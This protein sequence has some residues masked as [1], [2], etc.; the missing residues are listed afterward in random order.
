[1]SGAADPLAGV[2]ADVVRLGR[3]VV[4]ARLVVAAGGN[5]AV[6]QPGADEVVVTP[7]ARPLDELDPDELPVVSLATGAVIATTATGGGIP[8]T[9]ELALHLAA[10]RARPDVTAVLHLHPPATTLLHAVGIPI[11]ALTTDHALALA[12]VA[13][14]PYLDPGSDELAAAVGAAVAGAD[15]VLLRHH[16]CVVVADSADVAFGRAANVEAAAE[17]TFRARQLGDHDTVC[18]PR[19]LEHLAAQEARGIRYGR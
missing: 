17:A 19:Y 1:M 8:P 10:L 13:E 4:A 6:R 2:R 11:R 16:G 3:R 15:V 7:T 18:P 9:T 14:L 5:V 12:R